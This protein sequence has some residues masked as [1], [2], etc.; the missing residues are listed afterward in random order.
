MR[1][2]QI[3]AF[4]SLF[5]EAL[6]LAVFV[7]LPVMRGERAF[8][9]VRVAPDIYRARGRRLLRRYRRTLAVVFIPAGFVGYYAA[10]RF[11]EPL[12]SA[13]SPL[14]A[15]AAAFLVYGGYSRRVRPLAVDSPETRFASPLSVRRL[16]DYTRW[17]LEAVIVL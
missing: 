10:A 5:G 6:L 4:G 2:S 15:A 12:L 16:E 11:G 14:S 3:A 1:D 8:F 9:G 13:F 17:W 7:W